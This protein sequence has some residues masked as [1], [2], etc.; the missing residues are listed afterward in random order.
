MLRLKDPTTT[1]RG[2]EAIVSNMTYEAN[3]VFFR[4]S[5]HDHITDVI[6]DENAIIKPIKKT[7]A[8]ASLKQD[9][10]AEAF[11]ENVNSVAENLAKSMTDDAMREAQHIFDEKLRKAEINFRQQIYDM[12]T[13]WNRLEDFSRILSGYATYIHLDNRN[14][15]LV[16]IRQSHVKIVKDKELFREFIM[17]TAMHSHDKEGFEYFNEMG[18]H[19]NVRFTILE[20]YTRNYEILS[21]LPGYKDSIVKPEKDAIRNHLGMPI[22]DADDALVY[23]DFIFVFD[24]TGKLKIAEFR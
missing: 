1:A 18:S 23:D 11:R 10:S 24:E 3:P 21:Q 13:S 14:N 7:D 19:F 9:M 17:F 12:R 8:P 16:W 6:V 20:V 2:Y 22:E 5:Q 4:V 15:L